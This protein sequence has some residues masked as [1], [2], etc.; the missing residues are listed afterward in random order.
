MRPYEG[1]SRPGKK[2]PTKYVGGAGHFQRR[3]N[4]SKGKK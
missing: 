3:G 1:R 4:K 2:A